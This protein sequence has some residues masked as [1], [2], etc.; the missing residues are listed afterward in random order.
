MN[1][2]EHLWTAAMTESAT[3]GGDAAC[4]SI[5]WGNAILLLFFFSLQKLNSLQFYSLVQ[6]TAKKASIGRTSKKL[7][8]FPDHPAGGQPPE[9]S[10]GHFWWGCFVPM[11]QCARRQVPGHADP[12]SYATVGVAAC[13]NESNHNLNSCLNIL[14]G[15]NKSWIK[16]RLLQTSHY[17]AIQEAQHL[18]R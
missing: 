8:I 11:V 2:V 7:R 1:T 18:L 14:Y 9:S 6:N 15:S 3:K 12:T 16:T 17:E 4:S 13:C 5:S 10:P